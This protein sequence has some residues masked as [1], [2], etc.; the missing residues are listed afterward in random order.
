[1]VCGGQAVCAAHAVIESPLQGSVG[2][3]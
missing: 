1:M 2:C 3:C